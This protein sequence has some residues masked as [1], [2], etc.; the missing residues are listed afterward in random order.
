MS[1]SNW[2]KRN[3]KDFKQT[4]WY[5]FAGRAYPRIQ[6]GNNTT[7]RVTS[8]TYDRDAFYNDPAVVLSDVDLDRFNGTEGKPLCVEHNLND[9]VGEVF[10]SWIGDGDRRS[11]KIFGRVSLET[12]RGRQV[13]A[14]IKAGRY[15]GLSVGYGTDLVSNHRTGVTELSD[16]NFREISLV[17]EPFFDG[18]HLAEYGVTATK[19]L[20]HNNGEQK[21]NLLL[22]V[23]ASREIFS[24]SPMMSEQTLSTGSNQTVGAP[25]SGDELLG[26]AAQLK[27]QLTQETKAKEV[28][29]QEMASLK[30]ELERLKDLEKNVL[31]QRKAE[32][33]KYAAEQMPKFEAYVA[34]LAASKIPVTDA[35]KADLRVTFT[36]PRMKEGA[37]HLE[38]EYKQKIELRASLKAAEDK[39]KAMEE[40]KKKLESAVTKTT[41][42]LNHSRNEFASAVSAVNQTKGKEEQD[43]RHKI[44]QDVDASGAGLNRIFCCEPSLEE[45]HFMQAYGFRAEGTGVTASAAG[46]YGRTPVRSVPVAASHTHLYDE[47]GNRNNPASGRWAGEKAPERLFFA[48]MNTLDLATAD[49]SDVARMREDKNTITPK[50]PNQQHVAN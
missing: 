46:G 49:L 17:A 25:V 2:T 27:D 48:W 42:V 22:R 34:E 47:E 14:D 29:A 45:T 6:K 3:Q 36:D 50:Y 19:N 4:K 13:V 5:V 18:C 1:V 38:A 32:A 30:A 37:Q 16:K 26:Q 9:R 21:S 24:N 12:E 39:M 15:K 11:L 41:Q 35:M 23:D 31:A 10:H 8:D 43:D 7:T 44:Q 40:E 33:E 28:Q 20:N